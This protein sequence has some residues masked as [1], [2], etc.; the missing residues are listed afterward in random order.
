MSTL[1][2]TL[3]VLVVLLLAGVALA[4]SGYH[5][6]ILDNGLRV[7]L[8]EHHANP[9]VCFSTVV[10]AGAVHE[11]PGMNGSS[12]FLEHLLF[13]GTTT[14]TQRELYDEVDRYG[15]YNNATTREDH[16]LYMM[17]IQKEFAEQ[18]LD[19]QADMLLNSILPD[20][21]FTKEKGIVLE[22]LAQDKGRPGYLVNREF[23]AFAY[24]GTRAEMSVMGT[25]ESIAALQRD[26]VYA[27]Y[28]SRYVPN[29]MT[30]VVMGDLE[31]PAMLELVRSKFGEA[32]PGKVGG[33]FIATWPAAPEKNVRNIAND[34]PRQYIMATMPL[35]WP[36]HDPRTI[37]ADLLV[38][39]LA[40]GDDSPLG[41]QLRGGENPLTLSY[42]LGLAPR[43]GNGTTL[44]LS[45]TLEEGRDPMEVVHKAARGL[46]SL[47]PGW[48]ARQRVESVRREERTSEILLADQIHYYAMM[49]SSWIHGSPQ[50][51]LRDRVSMLD[52]IGD[53]LLGQ[54]SKV[55]AA[56]LAGARILTAGPGAEPADTT[57]EVPTRI[58]LGPV[59]S[60]YPWKIL[61]NGAEVAFHENRDSQVFALHLMF[62]P[63]SSAEPEG[64]EGIADFLHRM[65]LR[66]SVVIDK[67][68][69]AERMEQLGITLKSFDAAW[70]PYDDY[71]SLPEFSFIRLEMPARRWREG[72]SLLSELI[73]FPRLTEQ[74][75]EAVRREMLDVVRKKGDS[76][77]TLGGRAMKELLAPG[78]PSAANIY[79]SEQT[80]A[81]ITAADLVAFHKDYVRG[82]RVVLTGVGPVDTGE[83]FRAA[84]RGF[85]VLPGD[86]DEE[87]ASG[88]VPVQA[89]PTQAGL[90]KILELGKE[91]SFISLA[92]LFDASPKDRAA[93]AVAGALMSDRLAFT[94]REEQGLA[95]RIGCSF[96][97]LEGMSMFAATIGTRPDN[98][99]RARAAMIEV[100]DGFAAGK[101]IDEE[102]VAR[103]VNAVRGRLI[104]RRMS[105]VNQAYF[106]GLDRLED[107]QPGAG[108]ERTRSLLSVTAADVTRVLKEYLDP[109]RL[110][111]VVVR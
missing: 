9:M 91:Q 63:R 70:L 109:G 90:S 49:N 23:R 103:T 10:G 62:R 105:R 95:Y 59:C 7:I 60:S 5:E 88:A 46:Q 75:V 1:R 25:E 34:E 29:N 38:R 65:F 28:K 81:G 85:G 84:E 15:A 52:E 14:R 56:S 58:P 83:L 53:D 45:A 74:D 33:P 44:E 50:G 30:M 106:L 110:A 40:E 31:I 57:W 86:G 51:Y 108:L 76:A 22:E 72:V 12:H 26:D 42:S 64:K 11:P 41:R 39:A 37:A 92:Y 79:G 68:G 100:L 54:A 36:R 87:I 99:D 67:E 35:P 32:E 93:L 27:Y 21:K 48:E 61:P 71:Y 97:R 8:V 78:T 20:E 77:R 82:D 69:L 66:G 73:R 3:S 43:E 16:T 102:N 89:V 96:G 24:A 104:M 107:E 80:V 98:I 13:N 19:I 111:T 2:K 18:G 55:L 4:G 6:E 94:V 101:G 47:G 17:L